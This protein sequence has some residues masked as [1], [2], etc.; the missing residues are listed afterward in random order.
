MESNQRWRV[1]KP[2]TANGSEQVRRVSLAAGLKLPL[3]GFELIEQ[4]WE[5]QT[6]DYFTHACPQSES[7]QYRP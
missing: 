5:G 4:A 7:S 3:G 2:T 1:G 6:H